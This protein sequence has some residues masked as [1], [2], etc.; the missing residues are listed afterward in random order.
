MSRFFYTTAPIYYVNDA[1]HM[2]H[3]YT[4]VLADMLA[5]YHRL[6]GEHAVMLTGGD[7]HGERHQ[8]GLNVLQRDR[9]Q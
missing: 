6:C 3:T 1:P 2:G 4:T 5:R 8:H 9:V 7:E